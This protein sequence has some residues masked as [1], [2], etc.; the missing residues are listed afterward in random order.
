MF[1]DFIYTFDP[2]RRVNQKGSTSFDR[3]RARTD[4]SETPTSRVSVSET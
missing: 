1:D 3:S 4:T 2:S